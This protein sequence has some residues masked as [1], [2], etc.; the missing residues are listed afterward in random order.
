MLLLQQ[1][2]NVCCII[3]DHTYCTIIVHMYTGSWHEIMCGGTRPEPCEKF[4]FNQIDRERAV[5]FGGK[6]SK[7]KVAYNAVYILNVAKNKMVSLFVALVDRYSMHVLVVQT[8]MY[9]NLI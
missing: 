7:Y 6:Q 4:T 5:L 9:C 2:Y 1:Q 3:P 8:Y